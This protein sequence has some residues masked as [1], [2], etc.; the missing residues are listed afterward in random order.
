[1]SKVESATRA[2][3]ISGGDEV[4]FVCVPP[5]SVISSTGILAVFVLIVV[6]LT[7]GLIGQGLVTT[8]TPT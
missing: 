6:I 5:D 4:V 8:M 3:L 7:V 2:C 1:L